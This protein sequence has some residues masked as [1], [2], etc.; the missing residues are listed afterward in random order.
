MLVRAR[1]TGTAVEADVVLR[2]ALA[3][4][5]YLLCSDGLSVAVDREVLQ[6]ALSTAGDPEQ[7]VQRLI[8]L[9]QDQGA[10][11]NIACIVADFSAA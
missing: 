6:E 4:D 11:D 1:G 5:R 10:P 7:T 2:T 3:G 9:A 8:S